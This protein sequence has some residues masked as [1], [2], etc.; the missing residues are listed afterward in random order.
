[1][2]IRK[3]LARRVLGEDTELVEAKSVDKWWDGLKAAQRETV[4]NILGLDKKKDKK[5]AKLD[6]DEQDELTSYYRKH[7]GKVEETLGEEYDVRRF[8]E[9]YR[10][11]IGSINDL[12]GLYIELDSKQRK[13]AKKISDE[14]ARV[15]KLLSGVGIK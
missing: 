4:C 15:A 6:T 11:L 10:I 12:G 9:A 7:K 1:M 5:F 3:E 8:K 2:D 13:S 14:L